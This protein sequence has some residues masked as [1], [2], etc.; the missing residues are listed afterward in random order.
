[1]QINM[2]GQV[3]KGYDL[4]DGEWHIKYGIYTLNAFLS[5]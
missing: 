3:I 1:M 4:Q 5:C 2:S